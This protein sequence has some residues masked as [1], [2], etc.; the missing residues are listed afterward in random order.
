MKSANNDLTDI[1][2]QFANQYVDLY[3]QS[4]G[5]LPLVE[6]DSQWP[7]PCQQARHNEQQILWRPSK[8]I[9]PLIFNNIEEALELVLHQDIKTYFT[10]FFSDAI[11]AKCSEGNLSL[12]FAWSL[13]DFQRLQENII[14][15][16]LM[17][18]KLKQEVSIFFAVTDQEDLILSLANDSGAVWVEKVGCNPHKK[19]AD[20]LTEFIAMLQPDTSTAIA[21]IDS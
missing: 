1:L 5:H 18:R 6:H 19:L 12:L 2:W 7:S 15:H 16:V 10:T 11:D 13:D 17:K 3:Q 14:G 8:I 21:A 9:E 20:S 4:Q